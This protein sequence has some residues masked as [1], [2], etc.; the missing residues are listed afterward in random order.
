MGKKPIEKVR[1]G[2]KLAIGGLLE[3]TFDFIDLVE[4]N[5]PSNRK[6]GINNMIF[7][8]IEYRMEKIESYL[9]DAKAYN[10]PSEDLELLKTKYEFAKDKLGLK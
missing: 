8:V 2:L 4:K 10:L 7:R 1:E 5:N 9:S 3:D 6:K